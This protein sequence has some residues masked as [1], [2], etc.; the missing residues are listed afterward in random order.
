MLGVA[1]QLLWAALVWELDRLSCP[2]CGDHVVG[3]PLRLDLVD[4]ISPIPT[5]IHYHT[6][7]PL[8]PVLD[9]DGVH[10]SEP[11]LN[12]GAL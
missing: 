4:R 9:A 7:T 3:D 2:V 10:P 1:R 11:L 6:G 8:C 5:Y 12:Q